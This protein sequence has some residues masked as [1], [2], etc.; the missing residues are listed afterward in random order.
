MRSEGAG[1]GA[2]GRVEEPPMFPHLVIKHPGRVAQGGRAKG[3]RAL[4][5]RVGLALKAQTVTQRGGLS[6]DPDR[7]WGLVRRRH[8]CLVGPAD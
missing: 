3:F 2:V 6:R 1:I 5:L 7:G 8:R 4:G